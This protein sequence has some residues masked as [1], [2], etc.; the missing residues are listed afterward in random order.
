M[1]YKQQLKGDRTK[2]DTERAVNVGT[3][4]GLGPK[5]TVHSL[6]NFEIAN[7]ILFHFENV[8]ISNNTKNVRYKTKYLSD[9]AL[10]F[11]KSTDTT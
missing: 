11:K 6:C 7:R 3:G 1:L 10:Q 9:F 5:T 4:S 8:H 2:N